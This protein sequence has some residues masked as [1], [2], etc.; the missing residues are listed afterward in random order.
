MVGFTDRETLNRQE[1]ILPKT[2]RKKKERSGPERE[3]D[4]GL[5]DE[6]K[7]ERGKPELYTIQS[8]GLSNNN[9]CFNLIK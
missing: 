3:W 2:E 8:F 4:I 7:E 1:C 5:Q 9:G 6:D